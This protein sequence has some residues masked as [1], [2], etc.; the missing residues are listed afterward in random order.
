MTPK[1]D[2]APEES[3]AKEING[4]V[5]KEAETAASTKQEASFEATA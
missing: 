4:D 1:Y 5:A 2:D 3:V